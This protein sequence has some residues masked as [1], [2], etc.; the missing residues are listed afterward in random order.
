MSHSLLWHIEVMLPI[1]Y[2]NYDNI[3]VVELLLGRVHCLG[4]NVTLSLLVL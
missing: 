4:R 1:W 2:N 3:E